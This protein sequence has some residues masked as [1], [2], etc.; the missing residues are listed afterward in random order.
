MDK[1]QLLKD[2]KTQEDKICLS[3]ILDKIE[4]SKTRKKMEHTD[5][6]DMYQVA[7]AENFLRK[8][9]WKNYQLYGGYGEAERKIAIF[10]PEKYDKKDNKMIKV[11]RILLPEEKK[12]QYSHRSY[13]GGIVKLGLKREKIGDIIVYEEGADIITLE[14]FAEILKKQ[15]TS[16]ARFENSQI[17]IEDIQN[18]QKREVKIEII[19]IIV[20]SLR[21]D[22]LVSNFAR[23]S[24]SKA[25]KIIEQERV[26]IN[27]KK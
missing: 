7:L 14:D 16:L 12:G 25:V 24:R 27:R 3:Q 26:F 15:I 22:N 4:F 13:L 21:L 1:I 18:L 23:T 6:L 17:T 19:K 2:Y 10:Y 9:K 11:V 20:P 5:F 8:I